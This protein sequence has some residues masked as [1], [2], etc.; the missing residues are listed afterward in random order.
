MVDSR[1]M[2]SAS[3]PT[4]MNYKKAAE[5][6]DSKNWDGRPGLA[7]AIRVALWI[8]PLLGSLLFGF[9]ASVRFPPERLGVNRWLWWVGLAVIATVL[10]RV[11]E[12][13]TRRLTPLAMLLRLSLIF[14]D[15]APSRFSSALR[16]GTTTKTKKR[17]KAI[18]EGGGALEGDDSVAAQMLDLIGL[19]STHDKMTRGHAERV[20]GYT[21]LLSEELGLST[22][23]AGKLRWGAL[24]H[25]MGK[26]SVPSEILNKPGRPDEDEWRILQGHPAAAIPHLEP[27][28]DWLGEWRHAADGHHERWDGNGYPL[29]LAGKDI[30]YSARIVAV[31]DA[32]DVM[33]S[34]RSYK[35]ALPPEVARQEIA[36]NAGSQ[37]DPE[38][39]RAFLNIGLGELRRATGPLAWI[40]SLPGV[41]NVPIGN[42][43]TPVVTQVSSVV[44]SVVVA[45]AG[46]LTGG[47]ATEPELPEPQLAF[48]DAVEIVEAN[49]IT[50]NEDDR[51]I[52][53]TIIAS[54]DGPLEIRIIEPP[55]N[56]EIPQGITTTDERGDTT[57][58]SYDYDPEPGF[59][60]DDSFEVEICDERDVCVT[61]EISIT[62]D[63]VERR[64]ES[65]DQSARVE[66]GGMAV[67]SLPDAA[68]PAEEG[69]TAVNG[70]IENPGG[71]VVTQAGGSTAGLLQASDGNGDALDLF[72]DED[73]VTNGT[74]QVFGRSIVFTHDGSETTEATL[75][76]AVSDGSTSSSPGTI[77]FTVEPRND[78]PEAE[79][80]SV[81]VTG[82]TTSV[83]DGS[84][85]T[86]ND[87][88]VDSTD[89]T[90]VG[91]S[92][93][94]SGTVTVSGGSISYVHDGS[95]AA[96]DSFTY[97]V[98]DGDGGTSTAT[99]EVTITPA[100]ST[101]T[102]SS[103]STTTTTSVPAVITTLPTTTTT[104]TTLP[105]ATTTTTTVPPTTTTTTTT[106]ATTTI[107]PN[108]PPTGAP[109]QA[110]SVTEGTAGGAMLGTVNA[111]DP[112]GQPLSYAISGTPGPF[113]IDPATG[114]ISLAP[115]ATL[116]FETQST[117]ILPIQVTDDVGA[118]TNVLLTITVT[119]DNEAPV[120]SGS[121][122]ATVAE[123]SSPALIATA[124]A[125]DPDGDPLTY[126]IA[127]S[128]PLQIDPLTGDITLA[129]GSTF[130]FEATN[131][132]AF[133]V[134]A[135]DP[136]GLSINLPVAVT[137]TNVNE[138]P[139]SP[140]AQSFTLDENKPATIVGSV[141]TS[142]PDT[143][144]TIS[145][146]I[147]SGDPAGLFAASTNG[148]LSTTGPI[149]YE[150]DP[151]F[152]LV[153]I[154]TDL[155]G[156]ATPYPVTVT[157]NNLNEPPVTPGPQTFNIDENSLATPLGNVTTTDPDGDLLL[158]A[159]T[160][161]DPAGKL[162]ISPTGVISTVGP[163]NHETDPAF[164]LSV[165]IS[166]PD[167]AQILVPV[168]VTINDI[169]ENPS[170]GISTMT[171][172]EGGTATL[173]IASSHVDPDAGDSFSITSVTNAG[174]NSVS[175]SG[176]GTTIV[177]SHDGSET[178]SDNVSYQI[179]D[180]QGAIASG[181]IMVTITPVND[182]PVPT[183][184]PI[185]LT[186]AEHNGGVNGP[187]GQFVTVTDSDDTT[188]TFTTTSPPVSYLHL[189]PNSGELIVDDYQLLD[190]EGGFTNG[191]TGV[192]NV[193]DGVNTVPVTVEVN[194]IPI[195]EP[196]VFETGYVIV[197]PENAPAGTAATS[198]TVATDPEGGM[199][200]SLSPATGPFVIDPATGEITTT[201]PLDHENISSY[202]YTITVV[203]NGTPP[204]SDT[205][206]ITI[207]VG[208]EP[209]PPEVFPANF[210][211]SEAQTGAFTIGNIGWNDVDS[212][213]HTIAIVS[214]NTDH[215]GDGN[216]PFTVDGNSAN[217]A[218]ALRLSD[219]DDVIFTQDFVLEVEVTDNSGLSD[220][221]I[222]NVTVTP[223]YTLSSQAGAIVFNEVLWADPVGGTNNEFIELYNA[224][225]N[226]VDLSGFTLAD[227]DVPNGETEAA[228]FTYEFPAGTAPIPPAGYVTVW[229][230]TFTNPGDI[231]SPLST[232]DTHAGSLAALSLTD[233][234][235]LFD[236]GDNLM[237]YM[238]WGYDGGGSPNVF[239]I[240]EVGFRP[241]AT[242]GLWDNDPI[243]EK[244]LGTGP[245]TQ[246]QSISLA[247]DGDQLAATTASCWEITADSP[248]NRA[249]CTLNP[250]P[251]YAND[252]VSPVRIASPGV[253]NHLPIV[254][255]NLV[256]SEYATASS[257]P[258]TGE[259]I[260]LY[261]PTNRPVNLGDYQLQI[262]T[263]TV[264]NA[265]I[266]LNGYV[267]AAGQ[268]YLLAP[269]TNGSLPVA[270]DQT[271]SDVNLAAQTGIRIHNNIDSY[272]YDQVGNAQSYESTGAPMTPNA[273]PYREE[274]G[275]TA[276]ESI[277]GYNLS[278]QRKSYGQGSCVDALTDPENNRID[279]VRSLAPEPQNTATIEPCAVV[280]EINPAP[281]TGIVISEFR[282][283][284]FQNRHDD[285]LTIFNAGSTNQNIGGYQLASWNSLIN[286]SNFNGIADPGEY[287]L[288]L[289]Y[290]N[291]TLAPGERF[292]ASNIDATATTKAT[293]D[294]IFTTPIF[295][296]F[297]G[298]E[299]LVLLRPDGSVVDD[300]VI[301]AAHPSGPLPF[302]TLHQHR[303]Y[304]RKHN[305]C[306]D[307]GVHLND[308]EY[309][310]AALDL[311]SSNAPTPC[312]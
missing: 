62:I 94:S 276:L 81:T 135:T 51:Q 25:D 13:L 163:I 99:V 304:I 206:T 308:F 50:A 43:V 48:A 46:V 264:I 125:T 208:D 260:E 132:Y 20:R 267:L 134:T 139:L 284:G 238:A 148:D 285:T 128:H 239:D 109:N 97:T 100:A 275:V 190:L 23:D 205:D 17:L 214:G 143:P 83:I 157:I 290:P 241:P 131:P 29:G 114:Q 235:Y 26:L 286:D 92:G 303:S 261:N 42:A 101:T 262:N 118:I 5:S 172:L 89:L 104:T 227:V 211:I 32:Y 41:R 44:A 91:A 127:G 243:A 236:A 218:S 73:S 68:I 199:T 178:T 133:V 130:D 60:G 186:L 215:D 273:S 222:I 52:P 113:V 96:T 254:V 14:P 77:T 16:N 247:V 138:A 210:S 203:D 141:A 311:D 95:S 202:T 78:D 105:P 149:D 266:Q 281:A 226:P 79:D 34:T 54:G 47:G 170:S 287:D 291:R 282:P 22:E 159:I 229:T 57:T 137:I 256:L 288:L 294:A 7:R 1:T 272:D 116:D 12:R 117:Y 302:S 249:T 306:Q 71:A 82:G 158:Y 119:D 70:A 111:T 268:Y 185:V 147:A 38:V 24:L 90:V 180:S 102:S 292:R 115:N 93:A 87:T 75:R 30:P 162:T 298:R 295:D 72:V 56:G 150:T 194:L 108:L 250:L 189:D 152:S 300:V 233:D 248:Q 145:Y 253:N 49:D 164:G 35:K 155:A 3:G 195:N 223:R 307:T 61:E 136:D 174:S 204:L 69:G 65:P 269:T 98:A 151:T 121:V 122:I 231:F 191:G 177:Y 160:G 10:T 36:N 252:T 192:V 198:G 142:D 293:S 207:V 289:T 305:G 188:H 216:L 301:G 176:T 15:Q 258:A 27:I 120:S 21:D 228:S 270:A 31:A 110:I 67:L 263:D 297:F 124:A 299:Q 2:P 76:Y 80:D 64:P 165:T 179:T 144:D 153:V 28:A 169:N 37:F 277:S 182:P 103:T 53:G 310:F 86:D 175:T 173:D 123:N 280:P 63:S 126:A 251:T 257:S 196:P 58:F 274:E 230:G 242:F 193:S 255:D 237:A 212:T 221:A 271:Y 129:P 45:T 166:D 106:T 55:V 296:P 213:N 107:A 84:D 181:T 187:T 220:T 245:I 183:S 59:T 244:R 167:G 156:L 154:A 74:A 309:H 209:E 225:A 201:A 85:L 312:P 184:N 171:V 197:V 140:G 232:F 161:G 278:N 33:T 8:L 6:S 224:S 18:Q 234:L 112:E 88:D 219:A 9:W 265:N 200:F 11:L 168:A 246:N 283:N 19:L 240:D 39:A 4:Q 40:A 217:L 146:T 259:F 66:E 279:F